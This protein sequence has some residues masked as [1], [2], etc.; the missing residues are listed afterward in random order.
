[1]VNVNEAVFSLIVEVNLQNGITHERQF[2]DFSRDVSLAY[3]IF[4]YVIPLR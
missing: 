3:L 1:M 2:Y 4:R